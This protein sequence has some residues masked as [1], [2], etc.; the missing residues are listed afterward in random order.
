MDPSCG[1]GSLERHVVSALAAGDAPNCNCG[2]SGG[3]SCAAPGTWHRLCQS[4]VSG[5]QR[6][7]VSDLFGCEFLRMS[8][9]I[10]LRDCWLLPPY[11]C[12]SDGRRLVRCLLGL[13]RSKRELIE[14]PGGSHFSFALWSFG[15]AATW[16][17][18]LYYFSPGSGDGINKFFIFH[19][20]GGWCAS[21]TSCLERS[22][23]TLGST[24][25]DAATGFEVCRVVFLFPR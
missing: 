17:P 13:L 15:S 25:S 14:K 7:G 19:Q 23:G 12:C 10:L 16:G 8:L 24:K 2:R 5:W 3:S 4:A 22:K 11:S 1:W 21:D 9:E 20:G 18:G 6:L